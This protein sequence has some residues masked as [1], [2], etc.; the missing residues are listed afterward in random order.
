MSGAAFKLQQR[1]RD[2]ERVLQETQSFL[3]QQHDTERLLDWENR[4]Y[5]QIQQREVD[6]LTHELLRQ[7]EDELKKRQD[8]LQALYG[9]EMDQWK[10]RLKSKLEVTPEQRME[11]IRERAYALKA[12]REAE[13]QEFVKECYQRQWRD[14]CDD[15]RVIDSKA[16]MDRLA[17]DRKLMM[18]VKNKM[19]QQ[20][21]EIED[22]CDT[23][24]FLQDREEDEINRREINIRTKQ[25]LDQQVRLKREEQATSLARM[26]REEEEQTHRKKKDEEQ[27]RKTHTKLLQKAKEEG[28]DMYQQMLERRKLREEQKQLESEHDLILLKHALEKERC[29][30]EMEKAKK[31]EGKEAGAFYV[32]CLRTQLMDEAAEKRR[33]NAIRDEASEKIFQKNDERL[34]A[35]AEMKRQ[36]MEQVQVSRQEQIKMKQHEIERLRLEEEIEVRNNKAARIREEEAERQKEEQAKADRIANSLANTAIMNKMNRDREVEQQ[37]KFLLNKQIQ[38]TERIHQEK[39]KACGMNNCSSC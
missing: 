9:G 33:T 24:S 38:Y 12:K 19:E 27:L 34:A 39:M 20:Q 32:Q 3:R 23:M 16:I 29:A 4:T 2:Q 7:D 22:C 6:N 5:A 36:W 14:S 31:E 37:E 11:H 10:E 13:R 30:I 35:E 15:L 1:R 18:N 17:E 25:A 26:K 8:E 28:E 21:R